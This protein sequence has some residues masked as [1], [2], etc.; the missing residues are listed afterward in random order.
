MKPKHLGLAYQRIISRI[1]E[2]TYG[3]E[4]KDLDLIEDIS[5]MYNDYGGSWKLFYEGH[6]IHNKLLKK[7][8]KYQIKIRKDKN[9][10]TIR[11]TDDND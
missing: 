6:P 7:I 4:K 9:G 3:E 2:I 11:P 10:K 1:L 8:M 5:N